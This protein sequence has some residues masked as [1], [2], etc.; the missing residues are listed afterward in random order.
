M[1]RFQPHPLFR[2]PRPQ[3]AIIAHQ[4]SLTRLLRAVCQEDF[5]VRVMAQGIATP[6]TDEARFLGLPP[7]QR[8]WIREVQLEGDG[9]SWVRARTVL[10]MATLAGP[11]RALRRLGRRPLG[12]ALFQRD[13][14]QRARFITGESVIDGHWGRRSRFQR[15]GKDLLVTEYFQPIFWQVLASAPFHFHRVRADARR[16]L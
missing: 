2:L 5:R 12:S 11:E 6:T 8:A 10:P 9:S 14:W 15:R 3:R 16:P 4:G 7:R 1:S 13:P